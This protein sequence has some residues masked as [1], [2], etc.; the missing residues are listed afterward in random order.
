MT[1]LDTYECDECCGKGFNWVHHQV[2]ERK[3]DTQEFADECA[4]CDGRGY[5]GPDADERAAE[6]AKAAQAEGGA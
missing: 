3:S 6:E 2:A 4:T 1:D 5:I